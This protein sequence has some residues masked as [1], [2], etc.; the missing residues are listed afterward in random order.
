MFEKSCLF[1][2]STIVTT[3][4][5]NIKVAHVSKKCPLCAGISLKASDLT[6]MLSIFFFVTDD[7]EK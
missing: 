7:E 1:I 5:Y 2:L 3:A 4:G 6:S